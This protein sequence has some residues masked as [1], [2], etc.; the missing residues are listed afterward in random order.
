MKRGRFGAGQAYVTFSRVK[1]LNSLYIKNF[2]TKC[3][4][5]ISKVDG[6]ME[7][8]TSNP[9]PQPPQLNIL[10]AS[11]DSCIN[12]GH[13]NVHSYF[14]KEEDISCDPCLQSTHVMCFTETFLKPQHTVHNLTLNNQPV[15]VF[16]LDRTH[17]STHGVSG[18]RVMIACVSSLKP[19]KY[20][21]ST[22]L[23]LR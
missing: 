23:S 22:V 4:K 7:R 10:M 12:I 19:Q 1:S 13:L 3:L 11:A 16:R 15:E 2:E 8:L 21:S 17:E 9:L 5:T 20:L 18:G 6:E 14:A